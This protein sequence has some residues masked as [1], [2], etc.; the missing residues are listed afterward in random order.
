MSKMTKLSKFQ[1]IGLSALVLTLTAGTARAEDISAKKMKIKDNAVATKRQ[2]QVQ[3]ADVGVQFSET[4]DP[5]TKGASIHVYSATDEMCIVLQEGPEWTQKNSVWKYNNKLTKNKAQ[6]GDGK[7][8][9]KIKS[10][11]AFTLANDAP[12][13]AVNVQV[14]FGD[15]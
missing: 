4:D 13:D 9:V 2:F 5:A 11:V 7:L 8:S 1:A 6:I 15:A 12:Q 3:S 10:G 14:Q